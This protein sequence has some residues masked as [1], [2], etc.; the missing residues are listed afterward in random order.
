MSV[1]NHGTKHGVQ[2]C[3]WVEVNQVT[4][5]IILVRQIAERSGFKPYY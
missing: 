3:L 2:P 4:G 5:A 1:Y